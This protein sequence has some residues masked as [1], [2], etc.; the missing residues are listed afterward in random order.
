MLGSM[1]KPVCM[2]LAILR[3]RG[4]R[5][6]R[7]SAR[8]PCGQGDPSDRRMALEELIKSCFPPPLG[9][10]LLTILD[11]DPSIQ[12]FYDRPVTIEYT[13]AGGAARRYT[14]DVLIRFSR[15]RWPACEKRPLLADVMTKRDLAGRSDAGSAER[16]RAAKVYC[17]R[18]KWEFRVLT[19]DHIRTPYLANAR[20]LAQ[21]RKPE[22]EPQLYRYLMEQRVLMAT[23][24]VGDL[25]AHCTEDLG[26]GHRF[27]APSRDGD[28]RGS[29]HL[30]AGIWHLVDRGIFTADLHKP[31]D[32]SSPITPFWMAPV[33]RGQKGPP[34]VDPGHYSPLWL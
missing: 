33:T 23:A 2:D 17:T 18:R 21:H 16:F 30:L 20:F 8:R 1:D 13:G 32:I 27:A 12:S 29:S 31:L 34:R 4:G 5:S 26:A 6:L 7:A 3:F 9:P 22:L 11:F 10:D 24:T 14:P 15:D 28:P 25:L 19:E